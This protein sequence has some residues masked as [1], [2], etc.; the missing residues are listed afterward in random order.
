MFGNLEEDW[1][2]C[3]QHL[4]GSHCSFSFQYADRIGE[5]FFF[6]FRLWPGLGVDLQVEFVSIKAT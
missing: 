6:I 2:T 1:I 5:F 4:H 3:K